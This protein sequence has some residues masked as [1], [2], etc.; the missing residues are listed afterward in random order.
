MNEKRMTAAEARALTNFVIDQEYEAELDKIFI[1]IEQEITLKKSSGKI[2]SIEISRKYEDRILKDLRDLGY[3]VLF[4][5][6]YTSAY[7]KG[8]MSPFISKIDISW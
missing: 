7:G 4:H 6:R 2:S 5:K 3:V 1:L 8:S